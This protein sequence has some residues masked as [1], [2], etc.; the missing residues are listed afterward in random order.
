[1][2]SSPSGAT[3]SPTR[4]AHAASAATGGG[5]GKRQG[6][7]TAEA[8]AKRGRS[9]SETW[10][11]ES[12]PG[13]AAGPDKTGRGFRFTRGRCFSKGR[14]TLYNRQGESMFATKSVA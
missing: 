7:G 12:S 6:Q 2:Y 9:Q 8:E 1:M 3:E 14:G 13:T 5:A 10:T 4:H 11:W